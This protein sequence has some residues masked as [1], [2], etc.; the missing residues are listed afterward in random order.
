M[1]KEGREGEKTVIPNE[2]VNV[3]VLVKLIKCLKECNS[4]LLIKC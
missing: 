4:F 2:C 1:G 3:R